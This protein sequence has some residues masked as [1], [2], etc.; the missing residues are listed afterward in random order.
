M[1]EGLKPK[2][3]SFFINKIRQMQLQSF[4]FSCDKSRQVSNEI[5]LKNFGEEVKNENLQ[6]KHEVK[7]KD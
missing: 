5:G 7:V 4:G 2:L 1:G 6:S 3:V